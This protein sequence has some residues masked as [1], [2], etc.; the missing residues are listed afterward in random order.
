MLTLHA[1]GQEFTSLYPAISFVLAGGASE[2]QEAA[3][4]AAQRPPRP[5]LVPR[6]VARD[7]V[8]VLNEDEYGGLVAEQ[9]EGFHVLHC[10]H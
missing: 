3:S 5:N 6:R 8:V 2:D 7:E 1:V 9:G 4:L 10:S